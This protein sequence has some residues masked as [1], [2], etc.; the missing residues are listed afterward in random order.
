MKGQRLPQRSVGAERTLEP[1]QLARQCARSCQVIFILPARKGSENLALSFERM[2]MFLE[3]SQRLC[4][5]LLSPGATIGRLRWT[6]GFFH[7]LSPTGQ[8]I[9]DALIVGEASKYYTAIMVSFLA[10]SGQRV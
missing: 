1:V 3:P 8:S 2:Q 7:S 6:C 4:D 9:R 10:Y 5:R